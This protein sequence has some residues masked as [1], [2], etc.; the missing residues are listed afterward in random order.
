M[1]S[2]NISQMNLWRKSSL[3]LATDN[4]DLPCSVAEL[5]TLIEHASDQHRLKDDRTTTVVK[6]QTANRSYIIKRY[7]PR[8]FWHKLKR[9]LRTSRARRCWKMSFEFRDA[10]LN[11]SPPVLMLENR[12][13]PLRR[14]AFFVNEFLAGDELLEALPSMSD[15]EKRQVKHAILLAF[16]KL[17]SARISHGDMKASNLLWVDEKLYF[18]DL[19]AAQKHGAWSLL[20]NK[21]HRRDKRRFLKNWLESPELLSLFSEL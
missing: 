21:K 4:L 2:R 8:N 10:G 6:Y 7:N 15:A 16:K 3:Q 20:F 19:D 1:Q 11:V 14:D 13:G 18:I 9:A 5:N 12:F 17:A